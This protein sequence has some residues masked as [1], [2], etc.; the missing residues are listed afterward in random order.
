MPTGWFI[1][2]NLLVLLIVGATGRHLIAKHKRLKSFQEDDYDGLVQQIAGT[3]S[4]GSATEPNTAGAVRVTPNTLTEASN[5]LAQH[6]EPE[7]SQFFKTLRLLIENSTE[8]V[9]ASADASRT[10]AFPRL[11]L[12]DA[13][14]LEVVSPETPLLTVDLDLYHAVARRDHRAAVNFRHLRPL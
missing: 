10:T 4:P 13:V 6:Q 8:I 1:D 11:G 5:L 2:A 14:L 3:M 9:V 12:T 7:R